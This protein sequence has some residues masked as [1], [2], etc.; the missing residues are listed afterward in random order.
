MIM[1]LTPS[2]SRN[3]VAAAIQINSSSDKE[4]NLRRAVQLTEEATRQGASIVAL[5]EY[6]NCLGSWK[7][8]VSNAE[9]VPG[10]TS[11]Q[12]CELAKRLKIF[13]LAGSIAE[14]GAEPGRAYNTSLLI[15]PRGDILARYRKQHLFD[16]QLPTG[17]QIHESKHIIA[18]DQSVITNT[19]WG[20]L[21]QST[22]Y[23]LRFPELYREL[24]DAEADLV[25]VPS[26]FTRSTG[27]YHWEILLRARVIENQLFVLAPNQFGDHTPQ[28][29]SYGNS[30]II[31]PWGNILAR[32]AD[33]QEEVILA[34]LHRETLHEVRARIPCL[35]H[36]KN[37]ILGQQ[38]NVRES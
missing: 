1:K 6:F 11:R 38:F 15:G 10:P 37:K 13:L 19:P 4:R 36:R 21:G 24:A 26:A 14:V 30:M 16:V 5:P 31:D 8:I 20:N 27:R 23:D 28:L 33:D 2:A 35:V 22:C 12:M 25:F 32:A 17:V 3:A 34:E 9:C 18:G 7:E 29:T